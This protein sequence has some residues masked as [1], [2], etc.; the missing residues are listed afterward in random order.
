MVE[1]A[2]R[3]FQRD[4]YS[5]TSWRGLVEEA[6]TPWGSVHHHFPGGKVELAV[7]AIGFGGEAGSGLIA[8]C[9]ATQPDPATAVREMF[10]LSAAEMEASGYT[11][12][13]PVASV[14]IETVPKSDA[15][16]TA[17]VAA[18]T[19]WEK[20]IARRLRD[21]GMKKK[22]ARGLSRL[23]LTMLEGALVRSRI[24]RS[25]VPLTEAGDH[26]YEVLSA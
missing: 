22:R 25:T 6:G 4:G 19:G 2:S 7:A 5:G 23:T 16:A 20:L 3:L 12:A 9:F 13:C 24:E 10:R 8:H 11:A 26:L 21:A 15:M 17:A 18:F 1:T 14:A